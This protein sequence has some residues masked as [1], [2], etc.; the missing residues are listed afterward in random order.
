MINNKYNLTI[1]VLV[2]IIN[3]ILLFIVNI[4]ITLILKRALECVDSLKLDYG[5]KKQQLLI[6]VN[7]QSK[8]ILIFLCCVVVTFK[9]YL[10]LT[11]G[12]KI[13]IE[14]NNW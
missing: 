11:Y 4:C 9:A 2:F 12:F 7:L 3:I 13:Y 5:N 8:K 14:M 10:Q 6:Y 1:I